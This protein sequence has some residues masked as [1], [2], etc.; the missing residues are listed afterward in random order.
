MYTPANI[1]SVLSGGLVFPTEFQ[2][3]GPFTEAEEVFASIL[4]SRLVLGGDIAGFREDGRLQFDDF[5]DANVA[6]FFASEF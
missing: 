6:N 4:A 2:Q 5:A 1:S 3:P